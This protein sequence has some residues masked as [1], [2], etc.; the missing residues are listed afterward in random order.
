M[1]F[2]CYAQKPHWLLNY[3][4]YWHPFVLIAPAM[5]AG[6]G[7]AFSRAGR[8]TLPL[9]LLGKA[10]FEIFLFNVWFELLGK[11][12]GLMDSAL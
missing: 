2:Y 11:R 10:S 7:W 4:M 12:Y 9:E 3:A 6:L 8:L 5:C 1:L